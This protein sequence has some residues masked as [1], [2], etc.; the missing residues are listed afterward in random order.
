M[1]KKIVKELI[2]IGLLLAV[3]IFTLSIMFYDSL[4]VDA[5]KIDSI[6][7][8]SEGSVEDVINS[9][10]LGDSSSGGETYVRKVTQEE[11]DKY[12]SENSYDK[13]KK[14]PFAKSS[15]VKT[16]EKEVESVEPKTNQASMTNTTTVANT[17]NTPSVENTTKAPSIVNEANTTNVANV[18]NTTNTSEKEN[19]S[20]RFFE[21]KSSK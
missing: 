9:M 5:K 19:S 18:S 2:I 3:I 15:D 20:G 1:D 4:N 16:P 6:E 7:E 8:T 17:P 21:N 14:N 10:N 11:I 12:I 13:G